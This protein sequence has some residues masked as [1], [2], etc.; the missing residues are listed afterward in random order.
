[1]RGV[2]SLAAG[3]VVGAASLAS[4]QVSFVGTTS[5]RFNGAGLFGSNASFQGLTVNSGTFSAYTEGP[6]TVEGW[7]NGGALALSLTPNFNYSSGSGT[8]LDMRVTFSSPTAAFQTF[9]ADV[10]GRITS[11]GN[12]ILV[13][14]NNSP[15]TNIPYT[16]PGATGTFNLSV[17]N[18]GA[19]ANAASASA[20]TGSIRENSY[21]ENVTPT[22][23]PAS[24][25][26]LA[27]GLVGVIA[28]ARRRKNAAG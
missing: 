21:V 26:L 8:T 16:V 15:I 2:L 12:G 22:P 25:G 19:T 5:F 28:I 17:F 6:G 3:L 20:I 7:S 24:M 18:F 9:A 4:A 11:T 27:T 1:M 13:T 23:E 14:W 10:S